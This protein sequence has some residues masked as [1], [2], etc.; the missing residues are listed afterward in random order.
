MFYFTC[1]RSF[2]ESDH[3]H[4]FHLSVCTVKL[5][6]KHRDERFTEHRTQNP[7]PLL[8]IQYLLEY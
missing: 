3:H 7:A 2:T 4:H 1:D 5:F 8:E 6:N